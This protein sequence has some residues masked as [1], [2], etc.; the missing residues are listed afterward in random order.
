MLALAPAAVTTSALAYTETH[1]FSSGISGG[2]VTFTDLGSNRLQIEFDN[3]SQNQDTDPGAGV[4]LNSSVITGI[5]FNV[6]QDIDAATALSF[7]AGDGTDLLSHW[8]LSLNIDNE[9]TPGNTQFDVG[10]E[11]DTGIHAGLYNA[12]MPG[13]DLNNVFP[14]IATLIIQVDD[15]NPWIL[16]DVLDDSY[17]RMQRVGLNG[18]GSLKIPGD[19]GNP[20]AGVPEPGTLALLGLALTAQVLVRR[21]SRG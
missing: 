10:F 8:T 11:T 12:A 21:R 6:L 17:L 16:T 19:P 18:E 4:Y 15:P 1:V 13:T 5:V 2:K 9:L 20:P 3:T 14:D 7:V